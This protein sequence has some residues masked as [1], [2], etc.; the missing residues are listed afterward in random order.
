MRRS[1]LEVFSTLNCT[2]HQDFG[3]TC[4]LQLQAPAEESYLFQQPMRPGDS[5]D[6]CPPPAHSQ[7]TRRQCKGATRLLQQPL[8]LERS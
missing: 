8:S 5:Q 3:A 6:W 1:L 2:R 7:C 4:L